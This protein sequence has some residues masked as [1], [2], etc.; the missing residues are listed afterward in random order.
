MDPGVGSKG[1][2]RSNKSGA[3]SMEKSQDVIPRLNKSG[4]K[5]SEENSQDGT[6]GLNK[7]GAMYWENIQQDGTPSKSK[8][9]T[10][11]ADENSQDG[12][13]RLNKGSAKIGEN[14]QPDGTPRL[15][16]S[17]AK[18]VENSQEGALCWNKSDVQ[19]GENGL[20]EATQGSSSPTN[21]AENEKENSKDNLGVKVKRKGRRGRSSGSL[22]MK[23][24]K[25]TSFTTERG[26]TYAPADHVYIENN[27]QN[28]PYFICSIIDFSVVKRDTLVVRVKWYYRVTEVPD[29]VYQHLVQDRY[30]QKIE[31]D[32]P[33]AKPSVKARE[34]FCSEATDTYPVTALRGKCKVV[35]CNS[36]EAARTFQPA[37]DTFYCIL[38]YN[39]ET[40]RLA[41]TQGQIRVGS[42]YQA[43]MPECRPNT[44]PDDMPDRSYT[45]E[46]VQWHPK[47][48]I[49]NDLMMYLRAARSVA[50]FA[51]MCDG[52][53]TDGC[54]AA[55]M[56]DTTI[57]AMHM[58]HRHEYDTSKALQALVKG[59][60]LRTIDKK[61]DEESTKRFV[62]G[63]RVYGKNFFK[64]R[65]EL[66]PTK[67]TGELVEYY[68]FWKKTPAAA[69]N[70]PHR[71]HR[72]HGVKRAT[73]R[74]QRPASSEFLD[75]SSGSDSESEDSD[76]VSR[77]RCQNCL[78]T[79][80]KDWSH[81]GKSSPRLCSKC[82]IFFKK[83][84]VDRPVNTSADD[85]PYFTPLRDGEINGSHNMLTRQNRN[86]SDSKDSKKKGSSP[87]NTD[88]PVS[89]S[90]KSAPPSSPSLQSESSN[91]S[92]DR[93]KH[94]RQPSTSPEKDKKRR[95]TDS[96]GDDTVN[97]RTRSGPSESESLSDSSI[98]GT[99]LNR[100]EVTGRVKV[101]QGSSS[102]SSSPSPVAKVTIPVPVE[103]TI[104]GN[105]LAE[106]PRPSPQHPALNPRPIV[107]SPQ[108]QSLKNII[109]QT[110]VPASP[111]I[112]Q[113][114]VP[115]PPLPAFAFRPQYPPPPSAALDYSRSASV[116]PGV[117]KTQNSEPPGVYN[118]VKKPQ[119][120][121]PSVNSINNSVKK[122]QN[123]EAGVNISVKK[124]HNSELSLNNSA[125]KPHNSE[126]SVN[127][128]V[129]KPQISEPG[130]NICVKKSPYSELGSNNSV[131][132]TQN[133][134]QPCSVP[135]PLCGLPPTSGVT[136]VANSNSQR[137][138]SVITVAKVKEEAITPPQSPKR[139]SIKQEP[140]EPVNLMSNI[141][142]NGGESVN[143]KSSMD[144]LIAK[145]MCSLVTPKVEPGLNT[146][147][148]PAAKDYSVA[149]SS[150]AANR[151]HT[152]SAAMTLQ[153]EVKGR[154]DPVEV[155]K[156]KVEVAQLVPIT[157][158]ERSEVDVEDS[159]SDR[160]GTLTPGPVPTP[161]NKEILRSKT[162]I[163]IRLLNRG[164]SNSCSR[165]DLMFKPFPDS[166]LARKREHSDRKPASSSTASSTPA[167]D[168]IK[169][170]M[171]SP[172]P[173]STSD[174]QVVSNVPPSHHSHGDRVTPRSYS[175]TPAL[176][177][178]SEYAKPHALGQDPRSMPGYLG[179]PL[180]DPM[181]MAAM[182]PPNSRE[183]LELELERDKRE[184]DA[185]ERELREHE[186]R[187]LEMREKLKA[188]MEMKPP[189]M[190]PPGANPLDP[191]WLELQRRYMLPGGRAGPAHLPGIYPPT[192]I[193]TDLMAQERE[194]LER[195]GYPPGH[196]LF[197]E[198]AIYA[199]AMM[200]RFSAE[201]MS[202]E[203]M[204]VERMNAERLHAERLALQD[205]MIRLQMSGGMSAAAAAAAA[206]QQHAHTHT[207]AHSHTHLHLHQ[208]DLV[209]GGAGGPHGLPPTSS[210]LPP[211]HPFL[212]PH[213][214]HS[215][216]PGA[217]PMS[218]VN[219]AQTGTPPGSLPMG[220][221]PAHL[222][223]RTEHELLQS[224]LYRRAYQDPALAQQLQA[225]HEA[226]QRMVMDRERFGAGHLPPPH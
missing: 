152:N 102:P 221:P 34:L 89:E 73:T 41:T 187:S 51:G 107:S 143:T 28:N 144:G 159:D 35:H 217:D 1:T 18:L 201:R 196:P 128:S 169:R 216:P 24:D 62:K 209:P 31:S 184:R 123:S 11:S 29:S 26:I 112:P 52:G 84:G 81:A 223:G 80:S 104:S 166:K 56:D 22:T 138:T 179:Y 183:R 136:S 156:V 100:P 109:P 170:K 77:Y 176:R 66:L 40:K 167:K 53:N 173:S 210:A 178:L 219:G 213:L 79:V 146:P 211:H 90:K 121:E 99:E 98:S 214:L 75:L 110:S 168:E 3:K 118:S 15:N 127:N 95:H 206:A 186:L 39:P 92:T 135:P 171:E 180:M 97:K 212:P 116:S 218:G 215:L 101:T 64:I 2:P 222:M 67:E 105:I 13:V 58:L 197:G 131:K 148:P 129:K 202:V 82:R 205:P 38:G 185:R 72:K 191:H 137:E 48:V 208:P 44:A 68:Y 23:G 220:L 63:L 88:S 195:L 203:R 96:D 198:S 149:S 193:A 37:A 20:L 46:T 57:N 115:L 21:K 114:F 65:K 157:Q 122:P 50:A 103:S 145:D 188:E 85:S 147:Y 174:A 117:K 27:R 108:P 6:P 86:S 130:L 182:Y 70:R 42:M 120:P 150:S 189:G 119:N 78:D 19:L 69:A 124:P 160:E 83:Y 181:R 158:T 111:H 161:C 200:E 192:S 162:A 194:R 71:R 32:H 10:K 59:P 87:E 175:D 54:Q 199:A 93:E 134:E 163:F 94:K 47:A 60:A 126:P 142:K 113:G 61:W 164:K 155:Q 7:G 43:K 172:R 177:Q 76:G 49:D 33:L 132:K 151:T 125:K 91:C 25:I 36:L 106:L 140:V 17:G 14:S 207:H 204:S 225:H 165:C 139:I 154:V 224:D 4:T 16:K 153:A 5:S 45:L 55:A 190:L 8:S 133:S 226:L 141:C 12:S 9:G 74:S 30:T